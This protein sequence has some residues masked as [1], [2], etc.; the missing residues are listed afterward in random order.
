M[1]NAQ[2]S[3]G[4]AKVPPALS[5]A[6]ENLAR[7]GLIPACA[8]ELKLSA[9][10]AMDALREAVLLEIEAFTASKN[11]EVLLDLEAHTRHHIKAILELFGGEPIQGFDFVRLHAQRRAEQRFPLEATLHAHR[12]GH[13]VLSRWM[14]EAAVATGAANTDGV[15]AA[16]ADFAIEYTNAV[17]TIAT[18]EYVAQTRA[19]AAAEGDRRAE[20]LNL[21][22]TGYD[23]A[24]G[25]VG[26][27]L[28]EG[29]YLDKRHSYCV[30]VVRSTDRS[31]ME[32]AGRVERILSSVTNAVSTEPI[33]TLAGVRSAVVTL[34]A[35]AMRRQ[36]GWT[37]PQTNLAQ[38]LLPCLLKLGPSVLVG[39]STDQPSTAS[40]P[41]ALQE[42]VTALEFAS[43]A[44]RVV[45]FSELP[46]RKLMLHR[47]G[48]YVRSVTPRWA[49]ALFEADGK[50]GGALIATLRA[51]ADADL[52]VQQAGRDLR[53]HPNTIYGRLERIHDLTALNGRRHHDLV[54]LLLA[55]DCAVGS[56]S[57]P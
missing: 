4:G 57:A 27:L 2:P 43:V 47:S 17:S 51:L 49:A 38:R 29:G 28:K 39:I 55:A 26:R 3:T 5:Q 32:R 6:L 33:R 13:K 21:L 22:L 52:N 50:S 20:L 34:I 12:C 31:E 18:A 41:R 54:E 25:R 15:I 19:L 37:A 45:Q 42:A 16:V 44:R 36:S 23:E 24:D 30:A 1:N 35:S 14:R 40:I 53:V 9:N 11:P 56:G 8:A 7:L 10:S 46:I 48:D